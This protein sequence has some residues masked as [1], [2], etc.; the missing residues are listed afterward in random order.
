MKSWSILSRFAG[1]CPGVLA[2]LACSGVVNAQTHRLDLHPDDGPVRSRPSSARPADSVR[3]PDKV[4]VTADDRILVELGEMPPANHF[5]LNGRTLVFTPDGHGGY[6]RAVGSL[7]WESDTG[8][9]IE[10]GALVELASFGFDFAGRRWHSFHASHRGLLTFGE[11]LRFEYGSGSGSRFDTMDE[12]ARKVIEVPTISPLYKPTIGGWGATMHVAHGPDRV[13][14]TW[15]TSEREFWVHGE[16]P[17]PPSRFQAALGA[18]GSVT[19]SYADVSLG[20]GITGLFS[21]EG[22][23]RGD[24]IGSVVDPVDSELPGHLD[25]LEAAVYESNTEAAILV[26]TTREPIPTPPD[27]TVYSYRLHF[28][29]DQPWWPRVDWS[30]VDYTWL[31]DVRPDGL[32]YG[33]GVLGSA[34]SDADN[35]IAL[36]VDIRD[37]EGIP[38]S[39]VADAAEFNDGFVQGNITSPGLID[40]P[41]LSSRTIDLSQP[42]R[43][44]TDRHDE[45]FHYAGIPDTAAIACRVIDILGDSFDLFVFHSEF[46]VDSPE[47]STPWSAYGAN[48]DVTGTGERGNGSPPCGAIRLQGHWVLPV[49]MHSEFV[50]DAS[51]D[52]RENTGYD[53]GLSLFAH[54]FTHVWTANASYLRNGEPE[55]LHGSAC[56]CHWRRNLHAPAAFPWYEAGPG[57][58]SIMGGRYWRDNGDGTLTP[59]ERHSGGGHS[60]LDLYMMGLAEASEVPDMFIL[61][62]FRPVR[63]GDSRGPHTGEKEVVS[64]EQVVAAEGPREPGPA[65][66]QKD[67]NAGFVYLLEP[68]RSPTPELLD[69]HEKFRDKVIEHW[70]HITGGRSRITT[71]VPDAQSGQ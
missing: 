71:V 10:D 28:D 38:A 54:E 33:T 7:A 43:R 31:I 25:L 13:V 44:F 4:T 56:N 49:W 63:E 15:I 40:L 22:V 66:A 50:F 19:F 29:T 18:D 20:D 5:D 27:G 69:L 61:R 46:R 26:Y 42:D 8:A 65:Q 59:L 60:W 16:P 45:V 30:E 64:I 32:R 24:L 58:H 34:Q 52:H 14:V 57:A 21:A 47:A 55:P 51:P 1:G 62:N 36:L 70:S 23:T 6:S 39:V 9:E 2:V 37:V 35:Q 11:P 17:D 41:D 3:P 48:V 67:F 53:R 68:G 12:I